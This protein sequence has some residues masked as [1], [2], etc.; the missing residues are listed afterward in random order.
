MSMSD[1][2][3]RPWDLEQYGPR[4]QAPLRREGGGGGGGWD[5]SIPDDG[6]ARPSYEDDG[7]SLL[8][9]AAWTALLTVVTLGIYRFWMITRLRRYYWRAIRIEGDP[10]EY[11]GRGI[12]KFLG[13][14]IA[15]LLLAIYL[16][17]VNLALTFLGLTF[18]SELALNLSIVSALPLYFV[19]AYKARRYV[20]SRTRWRGIR[21]GMEP[22]SWGY[23]V[24]ALGLLVPT[25]LSAGILYPLM[26]FRLEKYMVDRT[27]FGDLKFEQGGSWTGLLA[28]WVRIYIVAA[29]IGLAAWGFLSQPE[30]PLSQA[31]AGVAIFGG[32]IAVL[33][34]LL[35][36]QVAAFRYLWSERRIGEESGF[37]NDVSSSSVLGIYV[38]GSILVGLLSSLVAAVLAVAGGALLFQ[39]S[40]VDLA[41]LGAMAEAAEAG[42]P[43]PVMALGVPLMIGLVLFYVVLAAAAY[44]FSQV[45]IRQPLIRRMSERMT[46]LNP[47][48][49]RASR[50]R[51]HDPATEAGGFA[52]ALGVDVGAGL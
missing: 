11:T 21:F 42:D 39:L 22:G 31:A 47:G 18:G 4:G 43:G 1:G 52:E 23:A 16:G 27:W 5:G 26:H 34:L 20:L 14:L 25:V 50:Q 3:V 6:R 44:A 24:R 15:I 19:A 7:T 17:L 30:D 51:A 46:I 9:L 13:F 12:E 40:G 41:S 10:L 49:L 37:V 35:L 48:P 45:F 36:Y 33:V 29:L 28:P 38:G 8:L 2:T 32:T